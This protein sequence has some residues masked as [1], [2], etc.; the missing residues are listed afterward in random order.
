MANTDLTERLDEAGLHLSEAELVPFRDM[1]A[2]MD[3]IAA[4]VRETRLS[5]A[6]EPATHFQAP[7]G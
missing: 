1:V 2:T 4:W 7:R 5:Y 6:E 3:R